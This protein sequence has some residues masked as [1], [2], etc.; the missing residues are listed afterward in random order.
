MQ[1]SEQLETLVGLVA[2]VIVSTWKP[3]PRERVTDPGPPN[4][5]SETSAN[6]Q[7]DYYQMSNDRMAASIRY[8]RR[9]QKCSTNGAFFLRELG[10]PECA[11]GRQDVSVPPYKRYTHFILTAFPIEIH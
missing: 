9:D 11:C 7:A 4:Y 2:V 5:I 10:H 3:A 1:I 6:I 8:S